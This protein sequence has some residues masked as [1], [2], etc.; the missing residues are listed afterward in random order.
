MLLVLLLRKNESQRSATSPGVVVGRLRGCAQMDFVEAV[1]ASHCRRDAAQ[2]TI[3]T[4]LRG[5]RLLLE[6]AATVAPGE[7]TRR[8]KRRQKPA[9]AASTATRLASCPRRVRR[10]AILAAVR[11]VTY[12]QLLR[13]N[14][15]WSKYAAES[16]G[17]ISDAAA[18]VSV[19]VQLDW[20]GA[21][22]CVVRSS[23]A[24]HAGAAGLV[25]T[26]TRRMLLLVSDSRRV[27][28]PKAG[29]TVEVALPDGQRGG[30]LVVQCDASARVSASS[31][32]T[33]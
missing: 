7:A 1:L 11:E 15:L 23:C 33:T 3:K 25:L 21:R 8:N 16:L 20:H 6:S 10:A 13:Q 31:A 32:L 30:G 22:V 27:W 26:E 17:R 4:K 5:R 9:A 29:T 2:A 18:Q 28:V 19:M 14:Q 12:E 24:S